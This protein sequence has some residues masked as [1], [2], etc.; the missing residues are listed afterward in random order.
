MFVSSPCRWSIGFFLHA[1]ERPLA[2]EPCLFYHPLK[3]LLASL[4]LGVTCCFPHVPMVFL[5]RPQFHVSFIVV[6]SACGSR[7]PTPFFSTHPLTIE[8]V[9]LVFPWM[10]RL[11]HGSNQ[12]GNAVGSVQPLVDPCFGGCFFVGTGPLGTGSCFPFPA[13]TPFFFSFFCVFYHPLGLESPP[14]AS[15]APRA[16]PI[17][18]R[19]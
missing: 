11:I 17:L 19:L 18:S 16:G 5:S 7:Q 14:R 9:F 10:A 1:R 8:A 12:R 2:F 13:G 15:F 3:I 6:S 4:P